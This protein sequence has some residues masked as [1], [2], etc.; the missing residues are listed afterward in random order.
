MKTKLFSMILACIL[1][2]LP[3]AMRAQT[4]A[5]VELKVNNSKAFD[6]SDATYTLTFYYGTK[7]ADN[8][9]TAKYFSIGDEQNGLPAWLGYDPDLTQQSYPYTRPAAYVYSPKITTAEFDQSFVDARPTNLDHWF[10]L[11]NHLTSIVGMEDYL[12]TEQTTSMAWTFYHCESLTTIDVS[13][14]DTPLLEDMT[15]TF[16]GCSSVTSLPVENFNTN[17][18]KKL[19]ITFKGC[20][21]LTRLDLSSWTTPMLGK[22][23]STFEGCTNLQDLDVSHFNTSG[24]SSMSSVFENCRSLTNLDLSSFE[25]GSVKRF[26][27]FFKGCS[28]LE[29]ID[30]SL[31][32]TSIAENTYRMFYNLSKLTTI[33]VGSGWDIS[34]MNQMYNTSNGSVVAD[35]DMFYGCTSL[36]GGAGT[37][38]DANYVDRAYA[39]VDGGQA[40]P[41]YLTSSKAYAVYNP[42][43]HTLY[44]C[45]GDAGADFATSYHCATDDADVTGNIVVGNLQTSED[46]LWQVTT[47]LKREFKALG[48]NDKISDI[49]RFVIEPSFAYARP[50]SLE[51][52]FS[53]MTNLSYANIVGKNYLHTEY[54][55]STKDMFKDCTGFTSFSIS[56]WEFLKTSKVTD[57]SGMFDGCSSLTTLNLAS[58]SFSTANVT[59]MA[60][61]FKGCS[62]LQYQ[63]YTDAENNTPFNIDQFNT[64]KVTNMEY[65]FSNCSS[66][67]GV[68]KLNNLYTPEV[69]SFSYMFYYCS[70]ITEI[71]LGAISIKGVGK[72]AWPGATGIGLKCMFAHCTNL[73]KIKVASTWN[74]ERQ[75][76]HP[77]TSNTFLNC[78]KLEGGNGTKYDDHASDYAS[79]NYA[80][81]DSEQPGYLT[82]ISM[83][84]Y[85]MELYDNADNSAVIAAMDGRKVK[86]VHLHRTFVTGE[87]TTLC[88]PFDLSSYQLAALFSYSQGSYQLYRL[89]G[90]DRNSGALTFESASSIEAGKAYLFK[91]ARKPTFMDGDNTVDGIAVQNRTISSKIQGTTKNG[92]TLKGNYVSQI[93]PAT[94]RYVLK[95]NQ[96][97]LGGTLATA[98]EA[99]STENEFP[100]FSAYFVDMNVS[101][102]TLTV[103]DGAAT[104]YLPYAVEIPNADFFIAATV[105]SASYEVV[106]NEGIITAT[107]QQ[108]KQGVIPAY[109][110]VFIQA[111]N[112]TYTLP[113]TDQ[114][115]TEELTN[116]LHGTLEDTPLAELEYADGS[117]KA[118]RIGVG[119]PG[120][121]NY[122][123]CDD[124]DYALYFLRRGVKSSFGFWYTSAAVNDHGWYNDMTI[125]VPANKAYLKLDYWDD[126]V[127][128]RPLYVNLTYGDAEMDE[129][130]GINSLNDDATEYP[131]DGVYYNLNGQRVENPTTGIYIVNGKKVFV[132]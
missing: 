40:N 81:I 129:A 26:A 57:M 20:Q 123:E 124:E 15:R 56:D 41:G 131:E 96:A 94:D 46:Y 122:V 77:N 92:L 34:G 113:V 117:D 55:T 78:E 108:I 47:L 25:T 58:P 10:Q 71:Q 53:G 54:A 91:P 18:L 33:Y 35:E 37:R 3:N 13:H 75:N 44:L 49:E 97:D 130:T 100:A 76:I 63:T 114:E 50:T 27:E 70:G 93:L 4:D 22:M 106:D 66:L 112:G 89:S 115:S 65:L 86:N 11:C 87:W 109:T 102:Y 32:N 29:V 61:M 82:E 111:N 59:D 19:D 52:W 128:S 107:L 60:R 67:S 79:G 110:G 31:F 17:A 48:T 42:T 12:K 125:I 23:T 99:P 14:F 88:L 43:T 7:P 8:T 1:A 5:Y 118:N 84:D 126:T 9:A 121:A 73:E 51:G 80:W 21:A 127:L 16:E 105:R 64:I 101:D 85:V 103:E 69:N 30:I 2:L 36:V 72:T 116:V 132:K 45:T 119:K 24:V 38:Y 39:R 95:A 83:D 62:S 28:N 6:A 90:Y 98:T 68:F 104:L 120:D 74:D